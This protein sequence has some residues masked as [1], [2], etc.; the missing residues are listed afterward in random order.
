MMFSN[1]LFGTTPQCLP[2]FIFSCGGGINQCPQPCAG[3]QDPPRNSERSRV[4]FRD[5]HDLFSFGNELRP[6][7]PTSQFQIPCHES[8]GSETFPRGEPF[9]DRL[10]SWSNRRLISEQRKPVNPLRIAPS[11][12][13]GFGLSVCSWVCLGNMLKHGKRLLYKPNV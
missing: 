7:Q 12:P 2:H 13:E 1:F 5:H 6:N 3:P 8:T 10:R 4:V 9:T 11:G